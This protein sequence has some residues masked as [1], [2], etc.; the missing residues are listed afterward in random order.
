MS[1]VAAN[2]QGWNGRR[3]ESHE[4]VASA[5][6]IPISAAYTEP[7]KFKWSDPYPNQ[8]EVRSIQVKRCPLAR[9]ETT[10][11]PR[12]WRRLR[13]TTSPKHVETASG[14]VVVAVTRSARLVQRRCVVWPAAND[15][16]ALW[17]QPGKVD[18]SKDYDYL[19]SAA[20]A[21]PL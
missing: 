13:G 3:T 11:Q 4:S 21:E 9:G 6:A 2:E 8:S 16:F 14:R 19:E 1:T 12:R 17:V 7:F 10:E 15:P 20:A 5:V 18:Q